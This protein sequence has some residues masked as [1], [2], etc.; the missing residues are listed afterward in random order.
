MA[1]EKS[2][3]EGGGEGQRGEREPKQEDGLSSLTCTFMGRQTFHPFL[4]PQKKSSIQKKSKS[5]SS[6]APLDF[7]LRGQMLVKQ[8]YKN[9]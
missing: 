5:D 6:L 2:G 8:D 9:T 7:T 3:R 4:F 1:I